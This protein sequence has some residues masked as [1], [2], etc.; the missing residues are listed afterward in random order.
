MG[1]NQADQKELIEALQ[2]FA[3]K[4]DKLLS[5]SSNNTN[6]SIVVSAGGIGV[7]I[8]VCLCGMMLVSMCMGAVWMSREFNRYDVA[9][10]EMQSETN[11]SQTYL[12]S[13]YGRM[14][15]W[16]REEVE[17]ESSAKL[18]ERNANAK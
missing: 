16:M 17:R 1:G 8:C 6:S 13:I 4:A 2:R 10:F 3:E 15:Q 12:A 5:M 14:P 9:L 11:R 18:K 7:W